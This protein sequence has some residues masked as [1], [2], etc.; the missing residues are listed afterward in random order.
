MSCDKR[1][2]SKNFHPKESVEKAVPQCASGTL[3][4]PAKVRNAALQED[5]Y[6]TFGAVEKKGMVLK[7]EPEVR[8][9]SRKRVARLSGVVLSGCLMG[10]TEAV[11]GIL[12]QQIYS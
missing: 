6:A 12:L 4:M 5:A 8:N 9:C 3:D 7:D 10:Q 2:G 11:Q 1:I